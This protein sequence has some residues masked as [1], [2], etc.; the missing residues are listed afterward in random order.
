M[1]HLEYTLAIYVYVHY[2]ICNIQTK[3]LQHKFEIIE[4]F[5]TYTCNIVGV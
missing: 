1:K 5:E 4:I 2:N 3:H